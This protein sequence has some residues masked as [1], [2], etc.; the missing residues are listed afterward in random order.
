[1][2]DDMEKDFNFTGK[3]IIIDNIRLPVNRIIIII[4]LKTQASNSDNVRLV[5]FRLVSPGF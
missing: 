5:Y 2:N 4:I 3:S 1:M